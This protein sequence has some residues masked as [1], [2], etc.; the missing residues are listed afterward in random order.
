M[1]NI[2]HGKLKA[3]IKQTEKEVLDAGVEHLDLRHQ[4]LLW[5][6]EANR[7]MFV[8]FSHVRIIPEWKDSVLRGIYPLK[9]WIPALDF[10]S[11]YNQFFC[12]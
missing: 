3:Q 2:S 12:V 8:D 4:N 9:T 6:Q 7:V 5:S 11:I 10:T 1:M